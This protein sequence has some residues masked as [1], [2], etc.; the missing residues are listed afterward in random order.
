MSDT[1]EITRILNNSHG[2]DC[3]PE[4]LLPLV[5]SELR[6]LAAAQDATP[7]VRQDLAFALAMR[8]ATKE[9]QGVLEQEFS[10]R[11][12]RARGQPGEGE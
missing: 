1:N 9:A 10:V 8:G 7:R 3:P 12:S 2:R 5:Y 4:E 6:T 11:K